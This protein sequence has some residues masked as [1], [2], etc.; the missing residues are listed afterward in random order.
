MRIFPCATVVC[1]AVEKVHDEI[2]ASALP[3]V[4]ADVDESGMF[5]PMAT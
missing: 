1:R 2:R 4:A 3:N 5:R